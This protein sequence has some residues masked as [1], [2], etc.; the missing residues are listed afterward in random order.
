MMKN[1]ICNDDKKIPN[2]SELII[3]SNSVQDE[4]QLAYIRNQMMHFCFENEIG[5]R[6]TKNET[7]R[8]NCTFSTSYIRNKIVLG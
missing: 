8:N 6:D 1:D 2:D 4:P 3:T 5:V 7:N